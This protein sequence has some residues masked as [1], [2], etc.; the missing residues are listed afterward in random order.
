MG[1]HAS[2]V[3]VWSL[4]VA[5][6]LLADAGTTGTATATATAA[7]TATATRLS[8]T[9][10][11]VDLR[12]GSITLEGITALPPP[13]P[14]APS[15]PPNYACNSTHPLDRTAPGNQLLGDVTMRTRRHGHTP[16]PHPLGPGN[17]SSASIHCVPANSAACIVGSS[18][19]ATQQ[20]CA[21]QCGGSTLCASWSWAQP[22]AR[23]CYLL[24]NATTAPIPDPAA[25]CGWKQWTW[26]G[27]GGSDWN[28]CSTAAAP[29]SSAKQ[30]LPPPAGELAAAD[31]SMMVAAC[32]VGLTRHY[33]AD[34][35][36]PGDLLL[37]HRITAPPDGPAVEIGGTAPLKIIYNIYYFLP[38]VSYFLTTFPFM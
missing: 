16:P 9:A 6:W 11:L 37:E 33:K 30:M 31:L 23:M 15:C 32:G 13:P 19:A 1:R 22:P 38:D 17:M 18:Q 28:S 20:E 29:L 8:T 35:N 24:S 2:P 5:A 4:A 3:P 10:F 7:A 14:S 36:R 27:G 26:A 34:P 12:P 21:A 25:D